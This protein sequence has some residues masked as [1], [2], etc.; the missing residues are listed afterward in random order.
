MSLQQ[1]NV[2]KG[3]VPKSDLDYQSPFGSAIGRSWELL[4]ECDEALFVVDGDFCISFAN[5]RAAFFSPLPLAQTIGQTCADLFPILAGSVFGKEMTEAYRSREKRT[6]TAPCPFTGAPLHARFVPLGDDYLA[7]FL[8]YVEAQ[9]LPAIGTPELETSYRELVSLAADW[10]FEVD[11][12]LVYTYVSPSIAG[13]LG[14]EPH[15][16]VGKMPADLVTDDYAPTIVPMFIAIAATRTAF[17]G[18]ECA[19]YAKNG[20]TVYQECSATPMYDANGEWTGYR[21][22]KRNITQQKRREAMLTEIA[23]R[24]S[25]IAETLQRSLLQTPQRIALP[26]IEVVTRYKPASDDTLIGGDL[27]DVYPLHDNKIAF[28]V[29]DIAGKGLPAATDMA[30]IKFLLRSYLRESSN[31]EA[32]LVRL[33]RQ[34]F[35]RQSLQVSMGEKGDKRDPVLVSLSVA[36]LDTL[37]GAARFAVAGMEPPL[38]IRVGNGETET[39]LELVTVGGYPLGAMPSWQMDAGDTVVRLGQGDLLLLY[40]DGVVE[41]RSKQRGNLSDPI[42]G[43]TRLVHAVRD[44]AKETLDVTP[45]RPVGLICDAVLEAVQQ[46]C[47]GERRDD[48]CLLLAR[49]LPDAAPSE[50][51]EM[52][53]TPDTVDTIISLLDSEWRYISFTENIEAFTGQLRSDMLGKTVWEAFPAFCD[54]DFERMLRRARAE[55]R[56]L[57]A[58][59]ELIPPGVLYRVSAE[60]LPGGDMEIRSLC[61]PTEHTSDLSRALEIA[62]QE[63]EIALREREAALREREAAL[64]ETERTRDR[65]RRFLTEI[66]ANVTE[67]RL[68]LCN[69]ASELPLLLPPLADPVVLAGSASLALLRRG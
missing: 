5:E 61:L 30:E 22:V 62:S 7:L 55:N 53:P 4:N 63:R 27:F 45:P 15:E 2:S 25:E 38:V 41:A 20:E 42:F 6:L 21:G 10:V 48:I 34:L 43:A 35:L 32:A 40:T 51:A 12:N 29:G 64:R 23:R 66:L 9:I 3:N 11:T 24:Q 69:A 1:G 57:V 28:V 49:Y 13:T 47:G 54:S 14:Y 56:H 67:G 44:A 33:N 16:I 58:D 65:Q 19:Y 68:R 39:R 8:R 50:W 46:F 31:P 36:V 17:S 37:T 18:L 26:Q 52:P 60:P 59:M